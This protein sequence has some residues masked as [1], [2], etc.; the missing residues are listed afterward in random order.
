MTCAATR[1]QRTINP[2]QKQPKL[3]LARTLSALLPMSKLRSDTQAPFKYVQIWSLSQHFAFNIISCRSI[4]PK[5]QVMSAITTDLETGSKYISSVIR[6]VPPPTHLGSRGARNSSHSSFQLRFPRDNTWCAL[7]TSP[8]TNLTKV[9]NSSSSAPTL[10]LLAAT[11]A[12]LQVLHSSSLVATIVTAI[13]SSNTIRG[14]IRSPLSAPCQDR[15][16]GPTTTTS[17]R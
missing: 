8:R 16:Y 1:A 17:T 11:T 4:S 12:R 13:L 15:L 7:N 10:R 14:Q 9:A 5:R 3:S 6:A 2:S